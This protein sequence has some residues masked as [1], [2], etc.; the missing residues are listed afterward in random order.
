MATK[1]HYGIQW[2]TSALV[3]VLVVITLVATGFAAGIHLIDESTA[4]LRR[5]LTNQARLV[6]AQ[7]ANIDDEVVG[8]A[9]VQKAVHTIEA[10]TGSRVTIIRHD[11][12]VLADSEFEPDLMDN[13]R[14][15]V[16]I[17]KAFDTGIGT[18]RRRSP[19]LRR[20]LL[21]VA[22]RAPLAGKQAVVRVAMPMTAVEEASR[23][24]LVNQ[25]G[26][27]TIGALVA[28]AVGLVLARWLIR[29]VTQLAQDAESLS[30]DE[31]GEF[32]NTTGSS[33][34][35]TLAGT[36]N[37]LAAAGRK[38]LREVAYE[39]NLLAT[40]LGAMSEAVLALDSDNRILHCNLAAG[41]LLGIDPV[42]DRDRPLWERVRL[43]PLV[44]CL[45]RAKRSDAEVIQTNHTVLG[46]DERHLELHIVP[47][48]PGAHSSISG[49]VVVINDITYEKR[50]ETQRRDFITNA[51]HELKTPLAVIK[52]ALET[53]LDMDDEV[54]PLARN[55]L[56]R[57]QRQTNRM[58]DLVSELSELMRLENTMK[59]ERR[60]VTV[61]EILDNA[62][63]DHNDLAQ[64]KGLEILLPEIADGTV[65]GDVRQ[66]SR[67]LGGLM[68]NAC[69]HSSGTFI[70]IASTVEDDRVIIT[71]K[72][73]GQGIDPKHHERIFERFYR[74]DPSR[75]NAEGSTGLGLA[76]VRRI[77]NLHGGDIRVQSHPGEG[78]TFVI[79]LPT[80]DPGSGESSRSLSWPSS[81]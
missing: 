11:G 51:S 34:L 76:M 45:D 27:A 6:S 73:N 65:M 10:N 21:Y 35:M 5:D 47:L 75:S 50:S 48:R 70:D 68:E 13:H 36:I 61:E 77:A 64:H 24:L 74:C 54:T 71:V 44:E 32:I 14:D 37:D 69:V 2:Q 55:F 72:D 29:P 49:W 59:T 42:T 28:L 57:S 80:A 67:M 22:V 12:V 9:D 26:M 78:C 16:E 41:S 46:D 60:R 58:T 3:V 43:A 79:D 8:A 25:V 52:G 63:S 81:T 66:L 40:I 17:D 39:Q 31:D 56:E 53:L 38:R 7:F 18:A 1:G 33:E 23:R 30:I 19:T 4:A 62:L 15:R 20:N